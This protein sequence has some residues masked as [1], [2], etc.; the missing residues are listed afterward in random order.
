MDARDRNEH[1]PLID[2]ANDDTAV[3]EE[4]VK[5][6][7]TVGF[8]CLTNTGVWDMVRVSPWQYKNYE[9]HN[10]CQYVNSS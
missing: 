5:A 10:F 7:T 3:S 9:V 6:L 4:L 8:A 1:V 2:M